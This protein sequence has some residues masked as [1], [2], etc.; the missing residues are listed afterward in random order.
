M[1]LRSGPIRSHSQL[2]TKK[3]KMLV[4]FATRVDPTEHLLP[5]DRK[6]KQRKRRK[7]GVIP[8]VNAKTGFDM[9]TEACKLFGVDVTQIPG[10]MMTPLKLFSEVGRDMSKWP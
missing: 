6:A 2:A 4:A 1:R 5:P 7:R 9:R 10:L 3:L 8:G